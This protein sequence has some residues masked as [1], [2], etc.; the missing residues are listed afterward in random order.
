MTNESPVKFQFHPNAQLML[1]SLAADGERTT[2]GG[3]NGTGRSAGE[4]W[5][6]VLVDRLVASN[7]V[8]RPL[9]RS[10]WKPMDAKPAPQEY[11]NSIC[12][13]RKVPYSHHTTLAS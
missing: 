13:G 8:I 7:K 5:D 9:E 3:H 6:G 11:W 12:I 10:M 4:G 2:R 1:L